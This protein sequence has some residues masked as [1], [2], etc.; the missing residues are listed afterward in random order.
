MCPYIKDM[1]NSTRT[2]CECAKFTFP[3]KIS[4]R[5]I[6]YGYCAHPTAWKTCPLKQT[7]DAYYERVYS[8]EGSLSKVN[9]KKRAARSK[10]GDDAC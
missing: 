5:S 6:I 9:G 8:S 3:D 2:V 10:R 4:R 7:L 1:R